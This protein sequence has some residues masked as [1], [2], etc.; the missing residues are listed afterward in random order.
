MVE[1]VYS[2]F[3]QQPG[4]MLLLI[5]D[6]YN[7]DA[8]LSGN[9]WGP[10]GSPLGYDDDTLQVD[11]GVR[12]ADPD[13]P[14]NQPFSYVLSIMNGYGGTS[15]QGT[16][17]EAK[18]IFTI[19]STKMQNNNGS[20]ILQINDL[21]ANS[22]HG[23]ALD[24]RTIPHLVAPGCNVDSTVPTNS[25]GVSGW[26][27]TSMASPH[28]SGAVA[29]FI[30]YYR[31]LFGSD[32]SPALIK[33]VFLPVA[34]DL[35]GHDDADGNTLGHPFDSK[36][37]WGRM[38]TNAVVNPDVMVQ[39]FDNPVIL[40]TT[41]QQ[42]TESMS[43]A[44][45][46][47]PVRL[48]LV[49]T[50]A[51]GHGLG[52]STPAWNNNLDLVVEAGGNTYY[53]NNFDADGWSEAGGTPDGINNT[54]GIFL[55]PTYAGG[56]TVRVVGSD[57]NSDGIPNQG[58][59]TDQDFALV[60][61][62]CAP[63]ADFTLSATPNALELCLSDDAVYQIEVG[64]IDDFSQSVTLSTNGEPVGTTVDFSQ[65]SQA[66]PFSSTLTIGNTA[67]ATAGSYEIDIVGMAPTSTHTTTVG[68]H[69][70][71]APTLMAPADKAMDVSVMP[72]FE[73]HSHGCQ[74]L[75]TYYCQRYQSLLA[76]S[77]HRHRL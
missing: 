34:H 77:G 16:P 14:G 26:C 57:L 72:T 50:D 74:T 69:L 61:Y 35:A 7:N 27:G 37:G 52:G 31:N 10:S 75:T 60:C 42:W 46:S 30:E 13:T 63:S 67:G 47:Q 49:W 56:F 23:P 25:Y 32:P 54:E 11:I 73:W 28:V 62:N 8:L 64:E 4:G 1:Q 38:D 65:N 17:D 22:A 18:N 41:G 70:F 29:L 55:G 20:Q 9:S 19:G 76:R 68:L 53:G 58:N 2:P 6:S 51:P 44:D 43:A 12:D 36:Q 5:N 71:D 66:P 48:M 40:D 24:G 59:A 15:S 39:Y 3:F 45:P 33:A 21:S